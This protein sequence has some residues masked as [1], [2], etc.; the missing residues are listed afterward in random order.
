MLNESYLPEFFYAWGCWE[1][2]TGF[3]AGAI[4][5]AFIVLLKPEEDVNEV[6]FRKI[7]EKV[8]NVLIFIAGMVFLIG[9]NIVRPVMVRFE[10]SK[11][12]IPAIVIAVLFA[13]GVVALFVKFFGFNAEK[14]DFKKFALFLL[15]F[16]VAFINIVYLVVGTPDCIHLFSN[17]G[18]QHSIA[19]MSAGIIL[20][21]LAFSKK[22]KVK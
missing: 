18:F 11:G 20:V 6:V 2:F 22:V 7:P 5:T 14:N 8:K 13:V 9:V 1:Y 19:I 10:D 12:M 21:Y 15:F 16:F 17:F 3:I 4:I